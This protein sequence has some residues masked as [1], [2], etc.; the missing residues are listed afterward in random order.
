M[1]DVVNQC[2]LNWM[3]LEESPERCELK[4]AQE[5][6]SLEEMCSSGS[7]RDPG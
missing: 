1:S 3:A 7:S 5:T 4:S 2:L 6:S